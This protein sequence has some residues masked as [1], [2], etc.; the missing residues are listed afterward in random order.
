[1]D[2]SSTSTDLELTAVQMQRKVRGSWQAN[3]V[4]IMSGG[5]LSPSAT[6]T[7]GGGG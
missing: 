4:K 1:M 7:Q 2:R 5:K 3:N 6:W